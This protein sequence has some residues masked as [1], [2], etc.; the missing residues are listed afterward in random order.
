[1]IQDANG[2]DITPG[3][4]VVRIDNRVLQPSEY[5]IL[6][7]GRTTTTVNLRMAPA[8][9]TG[10]HTIS[11]QATDNNGNVNTPAK[12]IS[13]HVS[14]EFGVS[15]LGSYPNPF[16]RDYMFI[17]YEIRGVAYAEEV[18]LEIYTVSGRKIRTL[19]FPNDDPSRSSGF[20]KGGTGV[21]TSL[22]YHEV[23]WDGRDDNLDEVANGPY[24]Y[25]L[26]VKTR[27]AVREVKGKFARVR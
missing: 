16:T 17:A 22:G 15:T 6:D 24:Y 19:S 3:K 20:L 1:V 13:V 12:E 23:W 10:S 18:A 21:P 14:N 27:D 4:T 8:L 26:R 25:V 11:V 2:I 7:S 5:V 9:S